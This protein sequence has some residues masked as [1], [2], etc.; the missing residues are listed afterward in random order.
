MSRLYAYDETDEESKLTTEEGSAE[1]K[2]DEAGQVKPF[3][4]EADLTRRV[5]A[6]SYTR[7]PIEI[8]LDVLE[9]DED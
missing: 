2:S 1:G 6:H 9:I 8:K 4:A 7:K 5:V 3:E